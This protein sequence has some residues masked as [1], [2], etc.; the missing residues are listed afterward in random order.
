MRLALAALV[1]EAQVVERDLR[2]VGE[3]AEQ[4]ALGVGVEA[5]LAVEV[6]GLV[7]AVALELADRVAQSPAQRLLGEDLG[8]RDAPRA[9]RR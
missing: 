3:L 9:R 7:A 6:A 4:T 1:D 8:A 2:L 5:V